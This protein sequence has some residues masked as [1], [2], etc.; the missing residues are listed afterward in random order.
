MENILQTLLTDK[1]ARKQEK[2]Q[3][4]ALSQDIL[5]PWSPEPLP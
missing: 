3:N 4:L 1:A 2:L 5:L